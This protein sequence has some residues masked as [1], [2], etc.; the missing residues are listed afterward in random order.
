MKIKKLL[1][2]IT[3]SGA[4]CGYAQDNQKV[5]LKDGSELVGY[6]SRQRPGENL[7]FT[8][9]RAEIMVNAENV[10]SIVDHQVSVNN[11][12]NEWKLWADK[13]DALMGNGDN[14]YLVLSDIITTKGTVNHVRILERGVKVKYLELIPNN[15]SLSWD[16]IARINVAP[17][18]KLQLTG[19]NRKY[20]LRSGLEYEGQYV[21]EIP[22]KTLSLL[23]DNGVTL[24]FN[25][26][27]VLKDNRYKI[28]PNQTLFE[29]S[30]LIDIVQLKNGKSHKGIIFERNYSDADTISNDY[31]LIQSENGS[32]QSINLSDVLEYRKEPNPI[33][34]PL[35]DVCL[36][37]GEFMVNRNRVKPQTIKEFKNIIRF[38]IDSVKLV[39]PRGNTSTEIVVESKFADEI[40]SSQLKLVKVNVYYEKKTKDNIYGFTYEDIVKNAIQPQAVETSINNTTKIV[41][42]V[43]DNGIYSLY[44]SLKKDAILFRIN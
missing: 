1:L 5:I 39:I 37:D 44:N 16:T 31:L 26:D 36:D 20:K 41:F 11:L 32:I 8:T 12:S 43:K 4:I 25:R 23:Q 24:V 6:I 42:S 7:T 30:D 15:Y 22:G 10:K 38:D 9:K 21:E 40:Q 27:E 29:Q 17:R 14:A 19:I 35:T 3:L 18:H 34:E 2:I 28:N 33:Y 13:N